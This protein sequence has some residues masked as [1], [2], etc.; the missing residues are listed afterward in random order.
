MPGLHPTDILPEIAESTVT[1]VERSVV[2]AGRKKQRAADESFP[3]NESK[4]EPGIIAGEQQLP[5]NIRV[6]QRKRA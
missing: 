3:F 1:C 2:L 4:R 6:T 5:Y